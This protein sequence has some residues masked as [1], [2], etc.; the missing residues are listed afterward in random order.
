MLGGLLIFTHTIIQ[1]GQRFPKPRQRLIELSELLRDLLDFIL[2]L[3]QFLLM[4]FSLTSTR[5]ANPSFVRWTTSMTS[6]FNASMAFD[7]SSSRADTFASCVS[8]LFCIHK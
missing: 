4:P 2:V 8:K 5:F 3:R 1:T 7:N 6:F